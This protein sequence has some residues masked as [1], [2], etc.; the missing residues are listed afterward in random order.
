MSVG[1]S[2]PSLKLKPCTRVTYFRLVNYTEQNIATRLN[3]AFQ[4]L[5]A[6]AQPADGTRGTRPLQL[7]RSCGTVQH[8]PRH[9]NW[10]RGGVK[11]NWGMDETGYS[12][13]GRWGRQGRI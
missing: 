4:I 1:K 11:E 9:P 8:F 2:T 10:I 5:L 7:K 3:T 13:N 12:N 6:Q